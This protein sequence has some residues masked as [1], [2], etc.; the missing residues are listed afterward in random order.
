[1][2]NKLNNDHIRNIIFINVSQN[3]RRHLKVLG[4]T[5]W[6]GFHD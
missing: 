6:E 2:T 3:V 1:M 5:L 4:L